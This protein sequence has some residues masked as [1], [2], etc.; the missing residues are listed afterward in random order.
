MRSNHTAMNSSDI[1]L[2]QALAYLHAMDK[3][4]LLKASK[5]LSESAKKYINDLDRFRNDPHSKEL[6]KDIF[7]EIPE[8]TCHSDKSYLNNNFKFFIALLIIQ[9]EHHSCERL[10]KHLNS[11]YNCF[12]VFCQVFRDYFHTSNDIIIKTEV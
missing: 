8:Y 3:N 9:S 1:T 7:A 12:D 2:G 6:I 10:I 4:E 11:C 5:S